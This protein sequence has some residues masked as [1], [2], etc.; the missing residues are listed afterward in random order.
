[1]VKRAAFTVLPAVVRVQ[2]LPSTRNQLVVAHS[3]Q[4][5]NPLAVWAGEWFSRVAA[6]RGRLTDE[7]DLVR[8]DLLP[9]HDFLH[10]L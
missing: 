8:L 6:S 2:M 1:V 9:F 10:S 4:P 3:D 5:G 7:P